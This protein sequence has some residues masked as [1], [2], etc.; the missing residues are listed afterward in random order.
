[1]LLA[2]TKNS[3]ELYLMA[4]TIHRTASVRHQPQTADDGHPFPRMAYPEGLESSEPNLL[5]A[6]GFVLS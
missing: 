1:M 5:F 4:F 3:N 2:K 6:K